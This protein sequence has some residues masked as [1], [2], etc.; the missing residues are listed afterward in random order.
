MNIDK[1]T[2]D[3]HL[4]KRPFKPDDVFSLTGLSGPKL[5]PDTSQVL[6]TISIPDKERNVV[7]DHIAIISLEN[8]GIRYLTKGSSPEWNPVG[9][10]FAYESGEGI[11]IYDL[12]NDTAKFLAPVFYS[13][14][15]IDHYEKKNFA[16]SPDGNSIAFVST[17]PFDEPDKEFKEIVEIDNILYKTKGGRGRSFFADH[18]LTHIWMVPVSGGVPELITEGIYNEHSISWSPDGS[19]IAFISNRSANPDN[20]QCNDLWTVDIKSKRI[21]RLTENSGT[22]FQPTWSP[23]GKHIA[24]L[25]ITG[26][27]S[28]NDSPA[29]DTHLLLV[30]PLSGKSQDLTKSLDRRI[31]NISWDAVGDSIYFTAGNQGTTPLYRVSVNDGIIQPAIEGDFHVLEYSVGKNVIAY[32]R[33]TVNRPVELFINNTQ[34]TRLNE[35]VVNNFSLQ[36]A[37]VFR[38]SSFDGTNVQGWLMKPVLFKEAGNY[39]LALVIHGGP[40]NMFG[41]DFED[42]M[43]TL[44]SSGYAV[45]FINPRGSSGYG[46]AFSKGNIGDWGG[47]DYKDLMAGLDHVIDNNSWIDTTNLFVTGQSYGGYMTNWI[48][49][50]TNRFKAAVVDGGI[51]NL[52]SFAGTSLY[53][54][55]IE[56]DFNA[57]IQDQYPLLWDASPLK[58]VKNVTT[59][60]LFLHG[61]LDNEVPFS[62]AE[63]M[64]MA[65]KKNGVKTSM[66][67]YAGEGH[68]W[69]PDMKPSN[70]KDVLS[71]IINW[72]DSY[73]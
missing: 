47:G 56:S 37:E 30:D 5:S 6:C 43:Q 19:R 7:T 8:K 34:L 41:Y 1:M 33:M 2:G 36:D 49:T 45:L 14:Y 29:E 59:P 38:F 50:R 60:V 48:I 20:N 67:L 54:S 53:H 28:T 24:C 27:I 9:S 51:S 44:A 61:Q 25:G 62:Q 64:Y 16:W 70:R 26:M 40:H 11:W 58:N 32:S 72:F 66:V 42:R 21:T 73:L 71:R 57:K 69:R 52:I 63:E 23:S 46:Q 12:L 22:A 39:P 18:H 35:S 55:L 65:L 10:K 13:G 68:G 4:H 17:A 3:I 15:F 31:E